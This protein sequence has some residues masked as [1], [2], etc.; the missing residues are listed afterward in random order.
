VI[1]RSNFRF[2]TRR[3][4][5]HTAM[6][7]LFLT[8]HLTMLPPIP[9]WSMRPLAPGPADLAAPE[10]RRRRPT[11][12]SRRKER[13]MAESEYAKRD[14]VV[15]YDGRTFALR[16]YRDGAIAAGP[17]WRSLIIENRTPLSYEASL[18]PDPASCL[19]D[20]VRHLIAGVEAH[21]DSDRLQAAQADDHE[22]F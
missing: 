5:R 11:L 21:D 20:A 18:A 16:A 14:M 22:R 10:I 3:N 7:L 19:A 13:L 1:A 8:P 12:T 17:Q 6:A 2:F 15:V 4:E 9:S